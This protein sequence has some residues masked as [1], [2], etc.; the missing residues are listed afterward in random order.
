ML[1]TPTDVYQNMDRYLP[2]CLIWARSGGLAYKSGFTF[3]RAPPG[4]LLHVAV[5]SVQPLLRLIIRHFTHYFRNQVWQFFPAIIKVWNHFI[6]I[7]WHLYCSFFLH[8][9]WNKSQCAYNVHVSTTLTL[10]ACLLCHNLCEVELPIRQCPPTKQKC[11][12][13]IH[14]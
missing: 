11:M 2:V 4:Y 10:L 5:D 8:G 6:A 1:T 9:S 12:Y 7:E 3:Q 14:I 13:T